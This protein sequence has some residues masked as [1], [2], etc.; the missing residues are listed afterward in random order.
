METSK[1]IKISIGAIEG[2]TKLVKIIYDQNYF[3]FS[4]EFFTQ[5]GGMTMG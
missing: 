3:E 4:G 5:N 2:L 1:I